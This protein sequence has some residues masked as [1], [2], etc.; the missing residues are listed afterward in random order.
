MDNMKRTFWSFK[1][2]PARP[3][4]T[5]SSTLVPVAPWGH[6]IGAEQRNK[7]RSDKV[8]CFTINESRL[9][10]AHGKTEEATSVQ[11]LKMKPSAGLCD[12][13]PLSFFSFM[14]RK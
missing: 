6:S 10:G 14:K 3:S 2:G 11:L 1:A 4:S 12:F 13:G 8:S 9:S 5:T 7:Q